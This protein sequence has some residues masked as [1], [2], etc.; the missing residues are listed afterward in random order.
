[1]LHS[2][3]EH[4]VLDYLSNESRATYPFL[5][6]VGSG[7]KLTVPDKLFIWMHSVSMLRAE[8]LSFRSE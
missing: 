1:M 4:D 5:M 3:E 8:Y 2:N 7:C 6:R